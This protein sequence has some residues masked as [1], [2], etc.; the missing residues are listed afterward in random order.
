MHFYVPP[1]TN[2]ISV[3]LF[4][5]FH[6]HT[7][8]HERVDRPCGRHSSNKLLRCTALQVTRQQVTLGKVQLYDLTCAR[9]PLLDLSTL[10]SRPRLCSLYKLYDYDAGRKAAP[11]PPSRSRILISR[12]SLDLSYL[13]L[14]V[15]SKWCAEFCAVDKKENRVE[16]IVVFLLEVNWMSVDEDNSWKFIHVPE[17][18]I[19]M[20]ANLNVHY[21]WKSQFVHV[22]R[23]FKRIKILN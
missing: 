16:S 18:V 3:P 12:D 5:F 22:Y 21:S 19:D 9:A 15:I 17:Y 10:S 8:T 2:R 11:I 13:L 20:L 23:A 7:C 1:L 6:A 14:G 4:S